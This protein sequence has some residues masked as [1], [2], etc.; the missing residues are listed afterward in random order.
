M[1][2]F[3]IRSGLLL[4]ALLMAAGGLWAQRTF[5]PGGGG[6][7]IGGGG[8]GGF[9]GGQASE[10]GTPIF[11]L[12]GDPYGREPDGRLFSWPRRPTDLSDRH[13][14]PTWDIDPHFKSDLFTF[15][16]INYYSTRYS[17]SWQ[18]DYPDSD[19][20]ISF[21]LPELTTIRTN[22]NPIWLKLTDS[23]L[24]DYP[25]CYM[26]EVAT[27]EFTDDEVAALRRYLLN[28]GFLMVDDFWGEE[29][30]NSFHKQM[31]RVFPDREPVDLDLSHPIF[32]TVFD[33]KEKPQVPGITFWAAH[34]DSNIAWEK[35][36][37]KGA[38]YWGYSDDKGRLVALICQ[39]T[40][41]GDGWSREL[42]TVK[43]LQN[44]NTRRGSESDPDNT[45]Y[46]HEYCEKLGYPMGVNIITYV[47]TH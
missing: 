41:L 39:N 12:N 16:R 22:P 11:Y 30:W 20:N 24:F 19:L 6:G 46:F 26:V 18:T 2:G 4:A 34:R 5:G 31:Q 35:P 47:M 1:A 7:G 37:A 10:D 43:L 13:G 14:T 25:F 33:L 23:K 29:A 17:D 44:L 21:R 3:S 38:H 27:L 42:S 36:D 28:G 32:H 9:R 40:D 15:V 45:R 8:R